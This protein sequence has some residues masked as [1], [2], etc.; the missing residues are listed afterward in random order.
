MYAAFEKVQTVEKCL[1]ILTVVLLFTWLYH[2]CLKTWFVCFR[3]GL[4]Y[5]FGVPIFGTHWNEICQTESWHETV[6]RLYYKYPF[7]RFVVLQGVGGRTEYLI[8]DPDLVQQIAVRDFSSFVNRI[9]DVHA[10]TDPLIGNELTNLTTD[11]W[12]RVR[13][14]LSPLLSG[15]KLKQIVI[16][17]LDENKRNLMEFLTSEL[18]E[19][20]N[21]ELVVDMMDLSTRSVID[22][23]CLIAFGIKVDSLRSKSNFYG[24][25]ESSQSILR[26]FDAMNRLTYWSIIFFPR[27]MKR[28]FGK[29][30]VPQIDEEFFTKSCKQIA[31]N[32]LAQQINRADYI[33]L[34]QS[35]DATKFTDTEII[36][37][38]FEF[39]ESAITE[40]NLITTF[41]VRQLAEHHDIQQ[42]LYDECASIKH[43]I[44]D[45]P[46]TYDILNHMKYMGMVINE[47][48]R[49]CPI[50]TELKR[51][52]TKPYVLV[53][54]NGE[55]AYVKPG[56]AIW[57]PTFTFQNDPQHYP[58]PS[59]FDPER[60]NAENRKTHTAGTYAPFGIG[61]RNCI[62]KIKNL[63]VSI[64]RPISLIS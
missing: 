46:L 24:F 40:N 17:S 11:D 18:N 52:A 3:H 19:N 64:Q 41:L 62:G 33:Q 4:K 28:I 30:L 22:G 44:N 35:L 56:D 59:V 7:E 48:L 61:P 39:Y 13:N 25:Y 53:N 55:K 20:D 43:Q 23:F 21:T 26:H 49:M 27:L 29:T 42:R 32:R 6:E 15:Q 60:F 38:V 14:L 2:R 5:D 36:A 63:I 47:A 57:L 51:R 8:R 10:I 12:R 1:C 45:Q 37:Q 34:L 58:N 16:P 50:A 9:G 31:D 54:S